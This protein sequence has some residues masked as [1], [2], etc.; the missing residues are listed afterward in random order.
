M[1]GKSPKIKY[2]KLLSLT[3]DLGECMLKSGAE[4]FRVEN[5]VERICLA[6]GVKYVEFFAIPSVIICSVQMENGSYAIQMRRIKH[7]K[8]DLYRL[9]ALNALSRRICSN[10]PSLEA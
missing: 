10:A 5:T 7:L 6:Y 3:L 2:Q 8:N 9:E 4:I 1:H